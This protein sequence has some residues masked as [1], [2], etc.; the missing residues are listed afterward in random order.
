M[1]D[2]Q[3]RSPRRTPLPVACLSAGFLVLVMV[4]AA[5][6]PSPAAPTSPTAAGAP[7]AA[8]TGSVSSGNS[9]TAAPTTGGQVTAAMQYDSSD[10]DPATLNSVTD[11]QEMGGVFDGL[12]RY[13]LGGTE[14]EP[15]LA[16][17]WDTGGGGTR[18]TF[19]LRQ[20]VRFHDGSPLSSS[21]VKF[22]F[23]RIKDPATK[24]PSAG[25]FASIT[26]VETPDDSTAVLVLAQ[27]EPS[28]LVTLAS[29]AGW[30]VPQK[31]VTQA[32]D[33]FH[34]QAVGT[35]AFK[36]DRW[37][38]GSELVL[39][40]NP[41]WWG[42]PPPL[43]RV[44]YKPITDPSTMYA[45]FD[46]GN[47]D[48]VQVTDPDKYEQ[49]KADTT[50]VTLT[51]VPGLITRFFGMN[52]RAKPFD[53]P[54]VREAVIRAIDRPG[55]VSGLFKGMSEVA[56]QAAAPGVDAHVDGLSQYE[57]DPE[58]AR[59]LLAQAGYPSGTSFEFW[60]PNIDRFTNPA[61]VVQEQLKAVGL[62]AQ[63]KVLDTPSLLQAIAKAQA[64]MFILSR[65]QE[66]TGD[67][68]L[69]TWF[70]TKSFPPGSNWAYVSNA[71][72]DAW[73]DEFRKTS[74]LA[75]RQDL[76]RKIEQAVNDGAYYDFLDHEKHI[77]A[78][79]KRI[80]GF[81]SDPFRSMKMHPVSV[82]QQ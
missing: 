32:G 73:I 58:K 11:Q 56:T 9:P 49:Y 7:S 31:I 26:S 78:V 43:D 82:T 38:P 53:S 13:R 68:L 25:L 55:L 21:D 69:Y 8:P 64:P 40:R 22:T 4:A 33:A 67:R 59:A 6:S 10:M 18:V 12:V 72:V 45:A 66:P 47:V 29:T 80:R 60:V 16:E 74:D 1:Q 2:S 42:G 17:S 48:I 28:L 70:H 3:S 27:P 54:Q 35:G 61:T 37:T 63:I 30:I 77:F 34:H 50:H 5:C 62:D 44:V 19:H 79:R 23:D 20:G 76:S 52:T 51:E 24:S 14:I 46:A 41:G 57:Y 75:K 36:L 15:A 81:V 65:G 39:A 71:D